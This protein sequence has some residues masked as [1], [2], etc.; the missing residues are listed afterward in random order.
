MAANSSQPQIDV[1]AL[2]ESL[3]KE[4]KAELDTEI[5]RKV[6]AQTESQ[7]ELVEKLRREVESL[8][9]MCSS[10][11]HE[12]RNCSERL[13][14]ISDAPEST[15]DL[16]EPSDIMNPFS[17]DQKRKRIIAERKRAHAMRHDQS[18]FTVDAAVGSTGEPGL[19]P[20]VPPTA[21]KTGPSDKE[22]DTKLEFEDAKEE[23]EPKDEL[24]AEEDAEDAEDKLEA[25][26]DAEDAEDELKAEE[27]E[28]E[29]IMTSK[30]HQISIEEDV[31]PEVL[32]TCRVDDMYKICDFFGIDIPAKAKKAKLRAVILKALRH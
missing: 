29:T 3:R 23:L 11:S 1:D 30:G 21:M 28:P 19:P 17:V 6:E 32:D 2:K 8:R 24:E 13:Q 26:E 9:S 31:T 5:R 12:M 27:D 25:E 20:L 16:P 10:L 22:D 18:M 4:L 15:G 7:N 14:T